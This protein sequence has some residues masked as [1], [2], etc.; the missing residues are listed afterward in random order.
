MRMKQHRRILQEVLEIDEQER[1]QEITRMMPTLRS[2]I[3][4]ATFITGLVDG[5][6][7]LITPYILCTSHTINTV[8]HYQD[9]KTHLMNLID[10]L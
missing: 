6:S 8:D 3:D 5:A 9:I 4:D 7:A 10:H 1:E 2:L